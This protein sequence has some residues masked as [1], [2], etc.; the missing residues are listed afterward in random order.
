MSSPLTAP[1]PEEKRLYDVQPG[2]GRAHWKAKI[3]E[4]IASVCQCL[5]MDLTAMGSL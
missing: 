4:G 2:K 5:K 3:G 1:L